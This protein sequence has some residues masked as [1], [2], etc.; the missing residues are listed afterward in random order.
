MLIDSELKYFEYNVYKTETKE[1]YFFLLIEF[2]RIREISPG[3]WLGLG[4]SVIS[5]Y[6][7]F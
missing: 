1:L 6:V 2:D 3:L 7:V 4:C 5:F